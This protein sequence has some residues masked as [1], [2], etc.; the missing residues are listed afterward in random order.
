VILEAELNDDL[1]HLLPETDLGPAAAGS[2]NRALSPAQLL[3]GRFFFIHESR[4]TR[5]T[6]G[7]ERSFEFLHATFGEFLAA[8]HIVEALLDLAGERLHQRRRRGVIDPGPLHV[9]TSFVTI[10]RRAPLWELCR[11]MLT[12]LD[13]RQ[14]EDCRELALELLADAGY[15]HPTWTGR[16][17]EPR[18]TPLAV[19]HAAFS[20][21][22]VC[23]VLLLS[24]G[25]VDVVELV[26]EPAVPN[27]R[28]QAL[29]WQSRL[30]PEDA[31][32]MWQTLRVAW[33]LTA[34][35]TRLEVRVEDGAEVGVYES[36][37][38]PPETRPSTVRLDEPTRMIAPDVSVRADSR[39]GRSL[40]RSAFVQ[41]A[42]DVR[43]CLYDLMPYWRHVGTPR[44]H[45]IDGE[46][47]LVSEAA[48][49]LD[50]LLAPPDEQPPETRAKQY[51]WALRLIE[52]PRQ[53]DLLITQL[54]A[55]LPALPAADL[56]DIFSAL[57]AS[58]VKRNRAGYTQESAA[59]I[60]ELITSTM[61][62]LGSDVE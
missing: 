36:T 33:C 4:A 6:A 59:F 42:H 55:E 40:R 25:P 5:D 14:R 18:R 30:E 16:D 47:F 19:R 11:E 35:P 53:R 17:Y 43:E 48:L 54:F 23:I 27:W 31:K 44:L 29:L 56:A 50:L 13:P 1:P 32:R 37:P 24:D 60:S 58:E 28:R 57:S 41:T 9:A 20:A 8:R 15:A 10:A 39:M 22:L 51:V 45:Q 7:P 21:N 49:F 3:V 52:A 61:D 34:E 2:M 26:G 38:W 46:P 62:E 12:R